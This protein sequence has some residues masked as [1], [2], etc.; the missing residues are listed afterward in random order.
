MRCKVFF[1][2]KWRFH[3]YNIKIVISCFY[4]AKQER[5]NFCVVI[6]VNMWITEFDVPSLTY[7]YNDKPLKKHL[8]IQ[9]ISR[10]NRKYP[11][12]E[13]GMIID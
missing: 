9:T 4:K 5:S 13:Y 7:M 8:L 10:V 3:A 1:V 2:E 6:V 11:G 12:K